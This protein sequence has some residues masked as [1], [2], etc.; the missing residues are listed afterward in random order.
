MEKTTNT[1]TYIIIKTIFI[2]SLFLITIILSFYNKI[3]NTKNN[4]WQLVAKGKFYKI[5]SKRI[6]AGSL[7]TKIIFTDGSDCTVVNIPDYYFPPMGTNIEIYRDK[8]GDNFKIK[9]LEP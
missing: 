3:L 8:N 9:I 7:F 2:I 1:N 5:K 6:I 4:N